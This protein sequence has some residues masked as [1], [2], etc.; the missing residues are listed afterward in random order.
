MYKI[1]KKM[2]EEYYSTLT[3]KQLKTIMTETS[4]ETGYQWWKSAKYEKLGE[5][6]YMAR[7]ELRYNRGLI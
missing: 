3:T 1:T 4:R 5:Q 6:F 2:K 7:H